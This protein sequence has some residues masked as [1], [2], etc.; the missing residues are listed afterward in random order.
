MFSRFSSR[1]MRFLVFFLGAFI[2]VINLTSS[3]SLDNEEVEIEYT[4]EWLVRVKDRLESEKIAQENGYTVKKEVR[5]FHFPT[6]SK[7]LFS[8]SRF[9]TSQ[10]RMSSKKKDIIALGG[11]PMT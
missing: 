11:N 5:S 9:P 8:H 2:C 4:N 3:D 6:V 7:K 1:I 10:T